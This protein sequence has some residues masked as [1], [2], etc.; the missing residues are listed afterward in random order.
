MRGLRSRSVSPLTSFPTPDELRYRLKAKIADIPL[1]KAGEYVQLN[2]LATL[3][4]VQPALPHLRRASG[5]LGRIVLVSSGA[6]MKGYQAL[7]LYSMVKAGMNSLCRTLA[8]EETDNGVG[9]WSIM[10]GMIDVRLFS[11]LMD[12]LR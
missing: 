6:S 2:L 8:A 9:V 7:G 5:D 10:P 12:H 1:S 11:T 3:Y 4:L